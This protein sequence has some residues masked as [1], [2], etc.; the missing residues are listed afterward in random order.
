MIYLI[1]II[2]I[3]SL[4]LLFSCK[5][6]ESIIFFDKISSRSSLEDVST[7]LVNHSIQYTGNVNRILLAEVTNY[8][9]MGLNG[10]LYFSFME[11]KLAEVVF[12]PNDSSFFIEK[13][14]EKYHSDVLV[15]DN[16]GLVFYDSANLRI[17]FNS[18]DDAL[19]PGCQICRS[20]FGVTWSD[21]DLLDEYKGKVW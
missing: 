18:N 19:I 2:S 5:N 11:N 21:S 6:K 4:V 10:D 17:Y 9:V 8:E 3:T 13:L 16:R 15:S 7:N 14:K 20:G 1:K 12:F